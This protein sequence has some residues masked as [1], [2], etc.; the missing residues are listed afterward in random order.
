[1]KKV[2]KSKETAVAAKAKP[3]DKAASTSKKKSGEDIDDDGDLPEE[4]DE[5]EKPDPEDTLDEPD[6]KNAK[7]VDDLDFDDLDLDDDDEDKY[8]NEDF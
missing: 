2:S 8:Y 6:D 1:M 5:Y 4:D 3:A 7:I